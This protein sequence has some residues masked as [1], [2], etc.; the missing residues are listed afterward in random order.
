LQGIIPPSL[1]SLDSFDMSSLLALQQV[2]VS[3]TTGEMGYPQKS[4]QRRLLLHLSPRRKKKT[5]WERDRSDV[6]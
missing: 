3:T 6:W 1:A 2:A 5:G 4:Q